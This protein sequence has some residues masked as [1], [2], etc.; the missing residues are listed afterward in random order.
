[1][2]SKLSTDNSNRLP[3]FSAVRHLTSQQIQRKPGFSTRREGD[4][5]A[6]RLGAFFER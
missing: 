2:K 1:V 5:E 4:K 6:N 3:A